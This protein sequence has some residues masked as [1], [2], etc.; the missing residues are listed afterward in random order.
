MEYQTLHGWLEKET[1]LS[2][3]GFL[4]L[5]FALGKTAHRVLLSPEVS[6]ADIEEMASFSVA[7]FQ[8]PN[9]RRS[10]NA[11]REALQSELRCDECRSLQSVAESLGYSSTST[12]YRA[13]A[14]LCRQVSERHREKNRASS[15]YQ[16][17]N[18]RKCSD[19]EIESAVNDALLDEIPPRPKDVALR[20]GYSSDHAIRY[21]FPDL[22]QKV[23]QRRNQWEKSQ[24]KIRR[25]VLRAAIFEIPPP[26]VHELC[27]RHGRGFSKF[28]FNQEADLVKQL[29]DAIKSFEQ[30]R[31]EEILR[32]LEASLN[33][34]PAPTMHVVGDRLGFRVERIR[35]LYPDIVAEISARHRDYRS[36]QFLSK[37]EALEQEVLEL[38]S[39]LNDAGIPPRYDCI[40]PLLSANSLYKWDDISRAIQKGRHALGLEPAKSG[41]VPKR[42]KSPSAEAEKG[43]KK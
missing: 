37:R 33:E 25:K 18:E 26:S 34:E 28:L 14:G 43:L 19:K 2:F 7:Q 20:L 17:P 6:K 40:I 30:T 11:I 41:P 9:E 8:R 5:S 23:I 3:E 24:R 42:Q 22:I 16:R 12:L 36:E 32:V 13:D 29:G 38:A 39:Q 10:T 31:K 27:A 1:R 15:N 35:K 21:R 4:K